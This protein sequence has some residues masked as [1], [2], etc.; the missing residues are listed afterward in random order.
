MRRA[1][2]GALACPLPVKN[3]LLAEPRLRVMMCQQFGLCLNRC[4]E[5]CL[6]HLSNPLMIPLSR[7]FEQG[8]IR[9]ILY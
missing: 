9:G 5:L 6:K 4:W 3:G 2:E 1:L 8:L 7:A